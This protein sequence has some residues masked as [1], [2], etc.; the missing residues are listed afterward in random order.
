M[1]FE[2][3]II[4]YSKLNTGTVLRLATWGELRI[5]RVTLSE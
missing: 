2:Y 3:P 1:I 4:G 5:P